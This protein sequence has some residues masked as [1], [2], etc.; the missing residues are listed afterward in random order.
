MTRYLPL[1]L[2]LVFAFTTPLAAQTGPLGKIRQAAVESREAAEEHSESVAEQADETE[3]EHADEHEEHNKKAEH[4]GGEGHSEYGNKH[5]KHG[6]H[7]DDDGNDGDEMH[8]P[9]AVA[10][11][12][13]TEGSSVQ[14]VIRFEQTRHGVLVTAAVTGLNPN[15][16]H[17]FHIHQFGDLSH[18]KGKATGGHYNPE[19]H[20][21][22][23]PQTED[24]PR[25][26]GDLGNLQADAEGN[27]T[28]EQLFENLSIA[29]ADEN[30]ILGRGVIIHAKTD[31][32]GQPTGNAGARI[33]QGV[34]GVADEL[35]Q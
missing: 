11:M 20:D 34:I 3:H 27:A 16:A 33:A 25:H 12:I 24:A 22:A 23:L 28:Y 10:T 9:Y 26:A 7:H 30:P 21:H 13:P 4:H 17:G 2:L 6:E 14:G 19:G 29:D 18:P 1:A 32:G 35:E 31:D 15:Q 5:N 8:V